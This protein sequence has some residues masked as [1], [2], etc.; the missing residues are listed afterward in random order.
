MTN[1]SNR[2]ARSDDLSGL[3]AVIAH[4]PTLTHPDEGPAILAMARM[5][6]IIGRIRKRRNDVADGVGLIAGDIDILFMLQRST[7]SEGP[8]VIDLAAALGVTTGAI[9]KRMQRLESIEFVVRSTD[10]DDRRSVRFRLTESGN[11]A[12]DGAR[13]RLHQ[14]VVDAL[15]RDEWIQ[16]QD[17]LSRVSAVIDEDD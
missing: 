4:S 11:N 15:S 2:N 5:L 10:S 3:A 12:A 16:L 13:A 8:R 7:E 9:S 17:L 1:S 6:R 14:N